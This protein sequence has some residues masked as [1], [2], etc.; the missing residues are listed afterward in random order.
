MRVLVG[1]F[2]LDRVDFDAMKPGDI[3]LTDIS[4]DSPFRLWVNGESVVCVGP[5]KL[6]GKRGVVE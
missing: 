5:V 6:M 4:A 1:S 3:L 2:E